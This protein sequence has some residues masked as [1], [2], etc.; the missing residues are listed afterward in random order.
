MLVISDRF[1]NFSNCFISA[2][3]DIYALIEALLDDETQRVHIECVVIDN[4]Y[5]SE[6]L[7]LIFITHAL[8]WHN[9]GDRS[10]D[11]RRPLLLVLFVLDK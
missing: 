6:A 11:V 9:W 7:E 4:E 1:G 10:T 5:L 8:N 2:V 3:C